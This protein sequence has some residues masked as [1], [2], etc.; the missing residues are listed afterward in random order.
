F[1]LDTGTL[2]NGTLTATSYWLTNAGTVSANLAGA[3]VLTKSG[4]GTATL[5]GANTYSGGTIVS[6]GTLVGN[7]TSLV[8]N[9]TNNATVEFGQ[10]TAGT[11]SNVISGLGA[12]R[13]SGVGELTL[14]NA[15]TYSGG[16]T[17]TQ[18]TLKL[19]RAGNGTG[20][21]IVGTIA[22][23]GGTL[24]LGQA[25][26]ISDSSAVTLGGGTINTGGFADKAGVLT[27]T[28]NSA[29]SGLVATTGGAATANDFLFSSVD[30]TNYATSSGSYLN[31]GGGYSYGATINISS[32]NYTGWSGY[33]TTS[34]NNFSDKV[35]FGSTGMKAQINFNGTTGLTYITA[36]PEPKVYVA[37]AMLVALV[38]VTEY[39]R[40]RSA[41][42]AAA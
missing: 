35:L 17:V 27:V 40:R 13:K 29:I 4:S 34:L 31:L 28:A 10:A 42:N 12:F 11:Y 14:N 18:G 3:G 1:T 5:S 38:G 32:S 24:L 33:S 41:K 26:Q 25:N 2:T 15:N 9:I 19:N 21:T 8:G 30:L 37:M 36:I 16:T 7:T 23:N 39:R 22:V 6:G 20:G